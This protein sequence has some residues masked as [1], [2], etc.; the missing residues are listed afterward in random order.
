MGRVKVYSEAVYRSK[1]IKPKAAEEIDYFQEL[2]NLSIIKSLREV[3]ANVVL[4]QVT[5]VKGNS[6]SSR[7]FLS[8]AQVNLH[9]NRQNKIGFDFCTFAKHFLQLKKGKEIDSNWVNHKDDRGRTMLHYAAQKGDMVIVKELLN[10]GA[11]KTIT[12]KYDFNPYGYALREEHFKVAMH[13]L[14]HN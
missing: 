10:H 13:I 12:D 11:D 14:I 6:S 3:I 4:E 8:T 1:S 7:K 2:V 5:S 9:T